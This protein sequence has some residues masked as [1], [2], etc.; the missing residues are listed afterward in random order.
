[1]KK[2]SETMRQSYGQETLEYICFFIRKEVKRKFM[3]I[4]LL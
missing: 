2:A 4:R 1:M 3:N